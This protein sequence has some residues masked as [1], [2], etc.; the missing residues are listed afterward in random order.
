MVIEANWKVT[1]ENT[2]ESYHVRSV[3]PET[4]ARLSATTAEF[5]I[6]HPHSSWQANIDAAMAKKLGKV[7]RLLGVKSGF[8]GYFHQLVFPALTLATTMG[9]SY[10]IQTFRPLSAET[11]EFTSYVFTARHEGSDAQREMLREACRPAVEFNRAVFDEDRVVCGEAQRGIRQARSNMIGELSSEE[12]RVR[13]FHRAWKRM[14]ESTD[15]SG[16]FV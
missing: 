15:T 14:M 6:D 12:Q 8:D 7:T 11:T 9:M 4:F 1:V 5:R 13:D 16:T 10:A 3:H 2:L